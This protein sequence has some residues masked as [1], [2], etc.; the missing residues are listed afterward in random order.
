[1]FPQLQYHV[2]ERKGD[3]GSHHQQNQVQTC[4]QPDDGTY[5]G[6][7]H[8]ANGNLFLA[9]F[10]IERNAGIHSQQGNDDAYNCK[11]RDDIFQNIFHCL[12]FVQII[13]KC[14]YLGRNILRQHF[15]TDGFHPFHDFFLLFRVTFHIAVTYVFRRIIKCESISAIMIMYICLKG[16]TYS[17][18]GEITGLVVKVHSDD[19]FLLS[20]LPDF[21]H[22]EILFCPDRPAL[23]YRNI[24][25][26]EEIQWYTHYIN[27]NPRVIISF[28]RH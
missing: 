21:I 8:F 26:G 18:N 4:K 11:K 10:C 6:S 27:I 13:L 16:G 2:N 3:G 23:R 15:T 5:S 19:I 24:H 28:L 17:T 22:Y 12:H 9:A 7:V 1:M 25:K 20:F 14:T